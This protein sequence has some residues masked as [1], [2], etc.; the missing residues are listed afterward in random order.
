LRRNSLN[1]KKEYKKAV[2]L[3]RLRD[4]DPPVMPPINIAI[5]FV[6]ELDIPIERDEGDVQG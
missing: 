5:I 4:S 2:S 1:L 6:K 3:P